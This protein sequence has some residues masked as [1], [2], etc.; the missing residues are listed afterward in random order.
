LWWSG[1]FRN[2]ALK[3]IGFWDYTCPRHGSLERYTQADWDL[4]LDDMVAGGVPYAPEWAPGFRAYDLDAWAAQNNRS[5]F[6]TI[7]AI[8]LEPRAAR[9]R[10]MELARTSH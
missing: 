9:L 10:L 3:E 8:R 4:L 7:K 6:T 5:D 2:W 1:E